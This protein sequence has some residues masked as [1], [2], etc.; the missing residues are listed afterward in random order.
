MKK[1]SWDM[2][3]EYIIAREHSRVG[4]HWCIIAKKLPGR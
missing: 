3:E 1:G 4:S 2:Q